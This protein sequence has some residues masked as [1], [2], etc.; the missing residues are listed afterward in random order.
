MQTK[1]SA[2]YLRSRLPWLLTV[3]L[4]FGA[5]APSTAE[6]ASHGHQQGKALSWATY[7]PQ[8][9]S[10]GSVSRGTGYF[11]P[12]ASRRVRE[13]QR[14]LDR[15]G[16]GAG[17]VDGFF[18]PETDAAVRTYQRDRALQVDGIVG[19]QTLERL[20]PETSPAQGSLGDTS[21][22]ESWMSR[23]K[24]Q[25]TVGDVKPAATTV[26]NSHRSVAP[27]GSKTNPTTWW[28]VMPF[29][30]M[31]FVI[32]LVGAVIVLLPSKRRRVG[33]VYVEGRSEDERIGE[34][35]G[36]AY[37]MG[38]DGEPG[39]PQE[40]PS[41]LVYDSSKPNPIPARLTEITAI[42][43]R[44]VVEGSPVTALAS[45]RRTTRRGDATVLRR[46]AQKNGEL[47]L[48]R[49]LIQPLVESDAGTLPRTRAARKRGLHSGHSST[50]LRWVGAQVHRADAEGVTP[51]PGT[52][53]VELEL[54]AES[55]HGRWETGL[56]ANEE[57]FLI[58]I[59]DVESSVRELVVPDWLP[60]LVGVL[61]KSG[62]VHHSKELACLPFAVELSIEVERAIAGREV[63]LQAG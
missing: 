29:V 9:W 7:Q 22:S 26:K 39:E 28:R 48:A 36:F 47:H 14:Q 34:F 42:D 6:T 56:L 23:S 27:D 32:V 55:E 17:K 8:G 59:G 16:Y 2:L 1:T 19:P 54:F 3:V 46:S 5:P 41:L 58:P 43:A 25:A 45:R 31:A 50:R 21:Q 4:M 60:A 13:V 18:G 35:R 51:A 49:A 15:L 10:A 57:P 11:R 61:A 20:R 12:G 30:A 53:A 33:S 63:L 62:M 44:T 40:T 24:Q 52:L 38:P 37:T